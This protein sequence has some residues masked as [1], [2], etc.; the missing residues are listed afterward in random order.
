MKALVD[1]SCYVAVAFQ[2]PGWKGVVDSLASCE[3]LVACPLLEAEVAAALRRVAAELDLQSFLAGIFWVLPDRP[4]SAEIARVLE[5][6]HLRGADAWHL[7]HA[8]WLAPDT[9][10]LSVYTL[11]EPQRRAAMRL[12][13][14]APPL[15]A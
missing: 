2:E 8:L 5:G 3:E 10:E 1:S 6:G 12:G 14:D 13:F 4:L 15:G 7:A 9:Q 11:D